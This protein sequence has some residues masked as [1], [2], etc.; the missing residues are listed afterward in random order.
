MKVKPKKIE[1]Q[2]EKNTASWEA[3][4]GKSSFVIYNYNQRFF[5][6]YNTT[7]YFKKDVMYSIIMFRAGKIDLRLLREICVLS[8]QF[9]MLKSMV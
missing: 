9:S 7:S 8:E 1:W 5:F 2:N 3:G 6:I 4:N